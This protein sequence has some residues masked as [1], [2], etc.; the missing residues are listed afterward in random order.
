MNRIFPSSIVAKLT[1]MGLALSLA[2]CGT[3]DR[4]SSIGKAPDLAPIENVAAPVRQRSIGVPMPNM[5]EPTTEANSLW[6]TGARQF[7]KDQRANQVG[8][9]LT[10]VVQINDSAA[11]ANATT[12][13]RTN[14]EDAS[15]DAFLGVEEKLD[16]LGVTRAPGVGLGSASSHAGSGEVDRQESIDLTIAGIVVDILPNGNLVVQG[17]QEVRVNFEVRELLVA[18]IVRP[19]DIR[20]DNTIRHTQ[21]AEARIAYGGRGQLTDVQQPRYGQQ[22][23]DIIFP[24]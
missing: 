18:G 7:F 8:D 2:G 19:E 13:T 23:Y 5:Q 15:I 11:I 12:R 4:I 14:S 10:V 16:G 22:L 9:I 6:R 1:V 3:V 21:M 20:S 17:R 24:F